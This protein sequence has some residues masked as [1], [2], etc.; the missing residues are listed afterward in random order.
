[1]N[2]EADRIINDMLMKEIPRHPGGKI[3]VEEMRVA[4]WQTNRAMSTKIMLI[5]AKIKDNKVVRR[6][7][8][9]ASIGC[10]VSATAIVLIHAGWEFATGT[11]TFGGAL[12]KIL[13]G[14]K[15]L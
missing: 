7:A 4:I 13:S 15:N 9:F 3:N 14:I 2:G 10:I 8:Y 12:L 11:A 1:M 6:L 5:D